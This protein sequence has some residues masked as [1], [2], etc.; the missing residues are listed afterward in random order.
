MTEISA[1]VDMRG[2]K[3]VPANR[4]DVL[5]KSDLRS[6]DAALAGAIVVDRAAVE[7]SG[8]GGEALGAL[9]QLAVVGGCID[10]E[11]SKNEKVTGPRDGNA[12][13]GVGGQVGIATDGGDAVDRNR[14]QDALVQLRIGR[15]AW[16]AAPVRVGELDGYTVRYIA[17][18][19]RTADIEAAQLAFT[20][21]SRSGC[22][23]GAT[24]PAEA[25]HIAQLGA[26]AEHIA[27]VRR[28]RQVCIDRKLL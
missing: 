14:H 28:R 3:L 22:W 9:L 2:T 23:G 13:L 11:S 10:P 4:P 19:R 6:R 15:V 7:R 25:L 20:A 16:N 1:P 21:G 26:Q 5:L 27:P 24:S 8:Q 18:R 12:V 17:V